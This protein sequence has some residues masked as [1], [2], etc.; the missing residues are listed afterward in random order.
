MVAIAGDRGATQL[1]LL[2]QVILSLQLPFA[3]VPLVH[4]TGDARNGS[5]C[6]PRLT[7][8]RC[9]GCNDRHH[10]AERYV[11]SR[12]G[13]LIRPAPILPERI[14]GRVQELQRGTYVWAAIPPSRARLASPTMIIPT[15]S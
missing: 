14:R 11:I 10:R 15:A 2:P 12:D 9:L 5:L 7:E 13:A 4:F 1:L 3:V 8:I 6:Q